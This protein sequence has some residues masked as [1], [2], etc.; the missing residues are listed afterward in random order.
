[1]VFM[2]QKE[3]V[4]RMAA[5]PGD[6]A[7]GR[8]SIMVQYYCQVDYLFTVKP[9][10]FTPPPKVDSAIV[11]L[12]P[13]QKRPYLAHDELLFGDIVREAFNHRRKTLRNSLRAFVDDTVWP[14]LPVKPEQRAEELSVEDYVKIANIITAIKSEVKIEK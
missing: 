2:L 13:Y 10:A 5:L 14:Q 6:P 3:V 8:L 7:Y 12:R 4:A 11:S 1:M 9:G